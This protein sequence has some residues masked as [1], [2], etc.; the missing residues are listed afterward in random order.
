MKTLAKPALFE[1]EIKHL[2]ED[3]ELEAERQAW[4]E[5]R[6]EIKEAFAQQIADLNANLLGERNA[7]KTS[8]PTVSSGSIGCSPCTRSACAWARSRAPR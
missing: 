2:Q 8:S 4:K 5:R 3:E 1:I 6:A 7:G